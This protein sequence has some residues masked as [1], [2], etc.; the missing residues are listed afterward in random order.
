MAFRIMLSRKMTL[1]AKMSDG[2]RQRRRN[3]IRRELSRAAIA[4]FVKNGFDRTTVDD[5]VGPLVSRRT[6]FRHFATKEDL[7]FVWY[8]DLTGELVA[9]CRA[10]P[11]NEAPY[12]SAVA[13]L[14]TL[15]R[16]YDEDPEWGKAMLSLASETPAL[17]AKSFE[18]RDLWTTALA[19]VL[20]PRLGGGR[21]RALFARIVAG[22]A[23][24]AFAAGVDAWFKGDAGKDLHAV[25]DAA[26]EVAGAPV[27]AGR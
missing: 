10:R 11:D 1:S 22:S 15:L 21:K 6:F 7:V 27:S 5:I 12:L 26:F 24:N 3:E 16:Y 18:K 23:V 17:L 2:L 20:A 9:A 25:V 13:A 4:L 19:E 14:R 8:E